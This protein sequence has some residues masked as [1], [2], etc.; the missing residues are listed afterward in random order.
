M[1]NNYK[2]IIV[3]ILTGIY[4]IYSIY[5]HSINSNQSKNGCA[6]FFEQN[7]LGKFEKCLKDG[8]ESGDA[9]RQA[10][11]ALLYV[12][13]TVVPKNYSMSLKWARLAA[14]HNEPNAQNLLGVLYEEGWGVEQN[15]HVAYLWYKKSAEQG[16][17]LAKF[18]LG[19]LLYIGKG[20]K[21]NQI[22]AKKILNEAADAGETRASDLINKIDETEKN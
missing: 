7:E 22:E 5:N 17:P 15:N 16:L 13:G 10:Q 12:D 4:G 21:A 20:V 8:A 2:I 1:K 9:H 14:E 3:F 18:N 6:V 11:L 19:R